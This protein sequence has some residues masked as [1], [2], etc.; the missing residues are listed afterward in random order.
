M[1]QAGIDSA[2][3]P[4]FAKH[5]YKIKCTVIWECKVI[6]YVCGSNKDKGLKRVM[7]LLINNNENA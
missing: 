2:E 4:K 5:K 7:D 6:E 3:A 1:T